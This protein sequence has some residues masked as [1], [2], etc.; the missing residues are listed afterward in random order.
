VVELFVR[1]APELIVRF[2]Q[3]AFAVETVGCVPPEGIIT[4]V[5]AVGTAPVLQ[6]DAVAHAVVPFVSHVAVAAPVFVTVA[7]EE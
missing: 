3:F 6:L 5:Q 2:L 1:V 7:T 4:S